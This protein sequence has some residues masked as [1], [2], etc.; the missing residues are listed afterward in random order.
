LSSTAK[1]VAR[2]PFWKTHSKKKKDKKT[3]A[4]CDVIAYSLVD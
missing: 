2:A 1:S 3:N 4:S